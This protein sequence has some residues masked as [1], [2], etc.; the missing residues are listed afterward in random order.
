MTIKY[1]NSKNSNLL[2]KKYVFLI[3]FLFLI[4]FVN[5]SQYSLPDE[6]IQGDCIE[7]I[8]TCTNCTWVNVT[9]IHYPPRSGFENLQLNAEMTQFAS[10]FN[11][12]FCEINVS[13]YYTYDTIGNPNGVLSIASVD[14]LITP[15]GDTLSLVESIFYLLVF[16]L[17]LMVFSFFFYKAKS[18]ANLNYKAV[19]FLLSYIIFVFIVFLIYR[20][21]T[22]YLPTLT[23]LSDVLFYVML[24][25]IM[26]IFPFFFLV[27]A[28]MIKNQFESI[29][30]ERLR[31]RG[32]ND[33][34]IARRS[35]K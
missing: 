1:K 12:T 18:S 17:S 25:S 15:T 27:I 28:Y 35:K 21:A 5:A 7:L 6:G 19:F 32:H 22:D 2:M 23:Y 29:N 9:V 20:L 30:E 14:F 8:Q 26:L 3:A 13:G 4:S 16:I 11:Y 10:T 31:K 24:I 34:S 33:A